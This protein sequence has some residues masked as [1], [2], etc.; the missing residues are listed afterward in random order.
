VLVSVVCFSIATRQLLRKCKGD[1]GIDQ[2]VSAGIAAGN[3]KTIG[4][5]G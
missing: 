1:A 5:S 2:G 3:G 4:F